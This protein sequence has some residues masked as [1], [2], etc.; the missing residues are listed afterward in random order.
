MLLNSPSNRPAPSRFD[1]ILC[2]SFLSSVGE[3]AVNCTVGLLTTVFWDFIIIYY[4]YLKISVDIYG[5]LFYTTIRAYVHSGWL[6]AI[7]DHSCDVIM[8]NSHVCELL[9]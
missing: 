8:R 3:I 1:Q 7:T 5:L 9:L 2:F 4:K 6:R